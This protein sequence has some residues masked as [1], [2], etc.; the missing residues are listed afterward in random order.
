MPVTG[1]NPRKWEDP[2]PNLILRLVG[3]VLSPRSTFA[4]VVGRPRVGGALLVVCLCSA[5]G[6]AL[7][8]STDVGR[9]MVL[10]E[11]VRSVEELGMAV[12]D[13]LYAEMEDG[14]DAVTYISAGAAFVSLPVIIFVIAGS[15]WTAGFVVLGAQVP[16]KATYAVVTHVG[17]VSIVQLL[18]TVPLN[19]ARGAM[20]RPTT[21]AA[22]LPV[23]EEGSFLQGAAGIVD[24]FVVW[25][26]FLLAIGIG[27]LY[28]RRTAPIAATLYSVYAMGAGVA[29]VVMPRLEGM[30]G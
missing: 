3:V 27:V 11:Q 15:V 9:E 13:E 7:L 28:K 30:V 26:L 5:I 20:G 2:L 19:F 16:F 21:V 8:L 14:L 6:N 10:T 17:A 24:L 22:L 25:Q 18:F 29:G 23:L 4:G 12:T 1:G